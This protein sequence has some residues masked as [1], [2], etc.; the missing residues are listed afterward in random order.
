MAFLVTPLV[1][2]V[3]FLLGWQ[4]SLVLSNATTIES[5]EFESEQY[6]AKR[7]RKVRGPESFGAQ[8]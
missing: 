8:S 7:E 2:G 1:I 3:G 5:F 4:L 6:I